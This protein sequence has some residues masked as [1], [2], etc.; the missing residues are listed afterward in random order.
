MSEPP[1]AEPARP[2]RQLSL[3]DAVCIMVG[4]VIGAGIFETTPRI[5][6]LAGGPAM[7]IGLWLAGGLL[8]LVGALCY[9]EL[10]TT[11]PRN[12][13]DYVYLSRAYGRGTG[14]IFAWTA[15][16]IVRPGN[17]GAMALIFGRYAAE[18]FPLE[19]GGHGRLAYAVAA[20]IVPTA[21]NTAH[22]SGGKWTQ[23][24]LT[25]IKVLG[26]FAVV[27]AGLSASV[28]VPPIGFG[29]PPRPE[30]NLVVAMVLVLFTYG[31]W[32]ETA[33][34]A[35]EVRKP[36]VNLFR[37][38]M[39]GVAALTLMYVAFTAALIHALGYDGMRRAAAAPALVV[40]HFFGDG[41]PMLA[42]LICISCLGS[43]HGMI[44]TGSRIFQVAGEDHRALRWLGEWNARAEV[45]ARSLLVQGLVSVALLVIVGIHADAFER[46]VLFTGPVFFF[47][48]LMTGLSLFILRRRDRGIPRGYRVFAYPV[49]PLLL[50]ASA[51]FMLY[52][53][54]EYALRY[55]GIEGL[56]AL[57]VLVTGLAF[58]FFFRGRPSAARDVR[59]VPIE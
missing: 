48:L 2:R 58:Y 51:A 16:W 45:P 15:F 30:T 1:T 39:F 14:F 59:Q 35:A 36:E 53:T 5:A 25:A 43:V 22:I 50:C 11:Y 42:V 19:F 21:L 24:V 40:E 10:A 33:Y 56:Y 3:V 4:V 26:L 18:L 7:L 27:V 34:V 20:V 44:L 17:I 49:T 57:G 8:A 38:L 28:T 31:G 37:A 29:S 6:E 23:N 47:F 54:T 9:A 12:G 13:G 46:L 41:R 52:A 55:G 32:S